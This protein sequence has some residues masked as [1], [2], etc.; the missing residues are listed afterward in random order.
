MFISRRHPLMHRQIDSEQAE[1]DPA[2]YPSFGGWMLRIG[3]AAAVAAAALLVA[4]SVQPGAEPARTWSGEF[5]DA[6]PP[7]ADVA[8]AEAEPTAFAHKEGGRSHVDALVDEFSGQVIVT[9]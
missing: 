8:A 3:I 2:S 4:A 7:P 5:Q 1:S 6:L 9:L